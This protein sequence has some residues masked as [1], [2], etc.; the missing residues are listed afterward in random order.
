MPILEPAVGWK[1]ELIGKPAGWGELMT[2]RI[3]VRGGGVQRGA[4]KKK[5]V[6]SLAERSDWFIKDRLG[7]FIHW[8]TYSLP[9]R[10][11]WV[12][13]REQI[14]DSRFPRYFEHFDPEIFLKP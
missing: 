1:P 8:G 5:K 4:V 13:S 10:H 3:A 7:L 6:P 2:C 9:A 12:K 14:S 11:E